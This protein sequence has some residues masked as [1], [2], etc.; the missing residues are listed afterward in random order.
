MEDL[1]KVARRFSYGAINLRYALALGLN[2][3]PEGATQEMRR[4][5]GTY[6]EFYYQAAKAVLRDMEKDKYPELKRV[7]TP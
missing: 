6:G 2:G 1:R 5:R 4:I 3:D 7:Q